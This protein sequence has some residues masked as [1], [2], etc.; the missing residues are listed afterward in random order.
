MIEAGKQLKVHLTRGCVDNQ[1]PSYRFDSTGFGLCGLDD[2]IGGVTKARPD[3]NVLLTRNL[4][5]VRVSGQRGTVNHTGFY[6]LWING[7][8][9]YIFSSTTTGSD[10]LTDQQSLWV[11]LYYGQCWA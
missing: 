6:K 10:A 8:L 1:C 4:V 2:S 3:L 7:R 11:G 5:R 9:F